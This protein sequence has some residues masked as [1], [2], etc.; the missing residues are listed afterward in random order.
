MIL[1]IPEVTVT[2]PGLLP[3]PLA[4]TVPYQRTINKP[5]IRDVRDRFDVRVSR[6]VMQ[7]GSRRM[8]D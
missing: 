5:H 1:I 8:V 6:G 7:V 3:L 4:I 2:P